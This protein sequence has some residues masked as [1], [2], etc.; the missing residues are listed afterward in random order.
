MYQT[1]DT[2]PASGGAVGALNW[3]VMKVCPFLKL[4]A[5]ITVTLFLC[6]IPS[7]VM[8]W[9]TTIELQYLIYIHVDP[10]RKLGTSDCTARVQGKVVGLN[11]EFNEHKG[12]RSRM[13][14]LPS[15][16]INVGGKAG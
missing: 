1:N 16:P 2:S 12:V 5:F 15:T 4:R 9:I 6:M 10:V 11:V 8:A 3:L 14:S 13:D 7:L